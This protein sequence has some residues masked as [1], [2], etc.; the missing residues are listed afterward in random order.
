MYLRYLRFLLSLSCAHV[1]GR[2]RWRMRNVLSLAL[3]IREQ[4]LVYIFDAKSAHLISEERY[5]CESACHTIHMSFYIDFQE[6]KRRAI[7]VKQ[8]EELCNHIRGVRLLKG[9]FAQIFLRRTMVEELSDRRWHVWEGDDTHKHLVYRFV[10]PRRDARSI[11]A[12]RL[13]MNF[14][15]NVPNSKAWWGWRQRW[16]RWQRFV[17][18]KCSS[19]W[20]AHLRCWYSSVDISLLLNFSM[21]PGHLALSTALKASALI[22]RQ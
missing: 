14:Y 7:L 17:D 1:S 20:T 18:G 12:H 3:T 13:I 16:Q 9:F 6:K 4:S 22:R 8:F 2:C 21:I 15:A 5:L 10:A 19:P 11:D